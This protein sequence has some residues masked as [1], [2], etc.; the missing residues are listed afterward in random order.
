MNSALNHPDEDVNTYEYC[1]NKSIPDG[2]NFYY[3]T[4]FENKKNKTTLITF[5]A[6]INE[7]QQVI[8]ECK[9]PGVARIKLKWWLE[10]ID[11][12]FD[13]KA[14]HPVTK[15]MQ[16]C[17]DVDEKLKST[18]ISVIDFFNQYIFIEQLTSLDSIL[19]LFEST[20][21]ELWCLSYQQLKPENDHSHLIREIGAVTHYLSCLQLPQTYISDMRCIVPS[22]HI[23]KIE[24]ERL[25]TN[26]T[27]RQKIQEEAFSPLI[28]EIKIKLVK[29][30]DELK[31]KSDGLHYHHI[32][33]KLSIKTCDELLSDNCNLLDRN[34]SLTPLRKLWIAWLI[35]TFRR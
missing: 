11:R 10:E 21:G 6:F 9:D 27:D 5:H 35:R 31:S 34:I 16:K 30:I 3:A 20:T 2:S 7:L 29:I 33:T 17:I 23:N 25:Q 4:L 14:R 26:F 15:Q 12:A 18:L 8:Y 22:S 19:S 13:N 24:L 32:M 28:N 1:V